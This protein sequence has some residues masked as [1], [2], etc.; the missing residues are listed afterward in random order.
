MQEAHVVLRKAC[1]RVP[2]GNCHTAHTSQPSQ[3]IVICVFWR[4]PPPLTL[5]RSIVLMRL[6][7][8]L[9]DV[10]IKVIEIIGGDVRNAVQLKEISVRGQSPENEQ[11]PPHDRQATARPRTICG[12]FGPRYFIPSG[13]RRRPDRRGKCAPLPRQPWRGARFA[14]RLCPALRRRQTPP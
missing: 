14:L 3:I 11:Q 5:L 10:A 4:S 6:A 7:V 8:P 12:C 9:P 13:C 1:P 2:G